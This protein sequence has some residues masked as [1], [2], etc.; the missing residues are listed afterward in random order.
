MSASTSAWS[1]RFE[2]RD[3]SR[4]IPAGD[5]PWRVE[6]LTWEAEGGPA[7]GELRAEAG[8]PALHDLTNRLRCGVTIADESGAPCWW[9]YVHAVELHLDGVIY[10]VTLDGLANRV[11]VRWADEDPY[12]EEGPQA[13]QY[14]TAWE[15]DLLSQRRYGV[16]EMVFS[17]GEGTQAGAEAA[18]RTHLV[19]RRRPASSAI[20]GER[21][22]RPFVLVHLRGW[23]ATL[24]WRLWSEPRG[25]A[26]NVRLGG[27]DTDF[28]HSPTYQ[29]V[30]QSFVTAAAGGWEAG[31]IWL[32]L[33]KVGS[34]TDSLA[35]ELCADNAGSPGSALANLSLDAGQIPAE[36]AWVRVALPG[37]TV[38]GPATTYWVQLRR[39]GAVSAT[40]FH[41]VKREADGL[42]APGV[43]KV[44][45]GATWQT[46]AVAADLLVGVFGR[47]ES[48]A[49]IANIC[50]PDAAGQFLSGVRVLAAS[51]VKTRLFRAG[52]TSALAEVHRLLEMGDADGNRLSARVTEG[53]WLLVEKRPAAESPR[54]RILPGGE[55]AQRNGRRL[56]AAENPVGQWAQL[57]PLLESGATGGE[58]GA[59]YIRRA[60]WRAGRLS[61][62]WE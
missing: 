28:G 20:P 35:V 21:L 23:Y 46:D 6:R 54:L 12:V 34:P 17:I 26:G 33:W 53:R 30:A 43:F 55:L 13:F 7:E 51:G 19:N 4:P 15:D 44:Y 41:R 60:E 14:Q 50:A 42:I 58:T 61:V 45:D 56:I 10:R 62:G 57:D 47:E 29:R 18:R 39:S 52:K 37:T 36:P 27:F 40:Q 25:F 3:F 1:V 22:E 48:T 38:L 9:G 49:Q 32:R 8:L 11:A 16:K 24:G 2:E 59:V 31:E 5:I